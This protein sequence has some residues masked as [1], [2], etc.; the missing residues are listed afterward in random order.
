MINRIGNYKL[1]R[2]NDGSRTL[3]L[4]V[5]ANEGSLTRAPKLRYGWEPFFVGR[6]GNEKTV[7]SYRKK[8]N[9]KRVGELEVVGH[10]RDG[11]WVA[12]YTKRPQ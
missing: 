1:I 4:T 2:W 11:R 5:Y 10:Y 8:P 3:Q 12:P 9:P 6:Y 7:W